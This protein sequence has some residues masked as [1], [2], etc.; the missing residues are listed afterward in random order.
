MGDFFENYDK[1]D[2]KAFH[3]Q[4]DKAFEN[5]LEE[6]KRFG[7]FLGPYLRKGPIPNPT[8]AFTADV[9]DSLGLD[10]LMAI[11]AD[12]KIF[13]KYIRPSKLADFMGKTNGIENSLIR[14][15]Q[16]GSLN[17]PNLMGVFNTESDRP[18]G[19]LALGSFHKIPVAKGSNENFYYAIGK[20][21]SPELKN[22]FKKEAF[23]TELY[24]YPFPEKRASPEI[25]RALRNLNSYG[26]EKIV[27]FLRDSGVHSFSIYQNEAEKP[28]LLIESLYPRKAWEHAKEVIK[29]VLFGLLLFVITF[30]F[31]I[32]FFSE[33]HFQN[34]I[35]EIRTSLENLNLN[36]VSSLEIP[37]ATL[38]DEIGE[39]AASVQ[40]M[41]RAMGQQQMQVIY[42][43]K[44]AS[45]GRVAG[46]LAHEINNP[47]AIL[48]GKINL[49]E[50]SQESGNIS[51]QKVKDILMAMRLTIERVSLIVS[52]FRAFSRDSKN[53]PKIRFPV[54]QIIEQALRLCRQR[55]ESVGIALNFIPFEEDF[56]VESRPSQ[57]TQVVFNLVT[58]AADAVETLD[59][60]WIEIECLSVDSGKI[61]ITITD[62]GLGIPED[63]ALKMMELFY[64]TKGMGKGVGLGLSISKGIIEEHG[65]RMYLDR[66]YPHT[67]FVI[68]LNL[69]A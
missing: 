26:D 32:Y 38:R 55:V 20:I 58:N 29:K 56:M 7:E 57:L 60:K 19:E 41:L 21:L 34:R 44:M 43:Y 22:K 30:T 17:R 15:A 40:S 65:G 3:S 9:L 51:P 52:A 35:Q 6:I 63:V 2:A 69:T 5:E 48:V 64:T 4:F 42:T 66:S 1:N 53:E 59:E 24:F 8:D 46:G 13:L 18:E 61:R 37:N 45:L 14:M 31:F 47:L 23:F 33:K 36:Q 50:K 54:K 11:G 68:E 39:L 25:A 67:R 10:Y 16:A 62:S 12:G 49:L 28:I 27:S